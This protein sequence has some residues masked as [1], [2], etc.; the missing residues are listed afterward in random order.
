[1]GERG[2]GPTNEQ[3]R[4]RVNKRDRERDSE[5]A[6]ERDSERNECGVITRQA[7]GTPVSSAGPDELSADGIAPTW[8]STLKV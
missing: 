6:C 7:V 8:T 4:E 3:E 2:K 1:M 5:R